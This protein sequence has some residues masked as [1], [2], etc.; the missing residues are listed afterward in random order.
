M[1][2]EEFFS[3]AVTLAQQVTSRTAIRDKLE[4]YEQGQI[5][6]K[7]L[8]DFTRD[9]LEDPIKRSAEITGIVRLSSKGEMVVAVGQ[10]FPWQDVAALPPSATKPVISEPSMIDG[11]PYFVIAAPIMT[12]DNKR[13]GTD[14][15]RIDA[16]RLLGIL[17]D[18][19]SLGKTG[20]ISIFSSSAS[21][22]ILIPFRNGATQFGTDKAG[23]IVKDAVAAETRPQVNVDGHHVLVAAGIPKPG[24]VMLMQM[25]SS[26]AT[27]SVDQ[28]IWKVTATAGA[29]ALLGVL[30]MLMVLRPLTGSIIVQANDM[31]RQIS[32]LEHAKADLSERH[33][34][35]VTVQNE[36]ERLNATL[37]KRVEE[38]TI[39][40]SVVNR[41]EALGNLAGGIAHEIN[42]PTQYIH[43]NLS[44]IKDSISSLLDL[45]ASAKSL[46]ARLATMEQIAT[47]IEALDLDY[48]QT[49]LPNA[50]DEA[51]HGTDCIAK[52]VL[53]IKEYS[54][55]SS[56]SS[57]PVDLNHLINLVSTVTHNQWKYIAEMNFQLAPNLPRIM[58][59]EG[60][61]NQMLVN[62]IVNAA[63]AISEMHSDSPGKITVTT[64]PEQNGVLVTVADTG[65]GIKP[66]NL[67]SIFDMFF[68][69]KPP[70]QG[71]GQGLAISQAIAHRHGGRI[72]ATSELGSGACFSVWLPLGPVF[73]VGAK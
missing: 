53:A 66:E 4:D 47:K 3:G 50:T 65:I 2:A 13:L 25:E 43:D 1:A 52:I 6:L 70:G 31:R 71:T 16:R 8:A 68:T 33:V 22:R 49:E 64:R 20:D 60:E 73:K 57:A 51:L 27:A 69:T 12:H 54:Y 34:Q 38:R 63:Q 7:T 37:E 9:K 46:S 42:T 32:D 44:F 40:L 30:G 23:K 72:W 62:L 67:K 58:A 36:L 28:L 5:S 18:G 21:P 35:L 15:V 19:S 10:P 45:A 56:Q 55:P 17:R 48:L 11:F 24:W 41:M 26:E 14:L 59:I 61:I 29:M 39:Q